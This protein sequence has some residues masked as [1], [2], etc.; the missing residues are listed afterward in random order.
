MPIQMDPTAFV[1][2]SAEFQAYVSTVRDG[3]FPI[4]TGEE[5]REIEPNS[6]TAC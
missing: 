2:G 1:I 4:M 3:L 6:E 5:T